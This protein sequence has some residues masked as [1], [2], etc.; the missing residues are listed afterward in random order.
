M[1]ANMAKPPLRWAS[2]AATDSRSSEPR[3]TQGRGTVLGQ[4]AGRI[5]HRKGGDVACFWMARDGAGTRDDYAELP[6]EVP[7]LRST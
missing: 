4:V 2:A 7:H 5:H 1:L 6:V 3:H